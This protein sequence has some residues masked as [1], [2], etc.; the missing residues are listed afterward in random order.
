MEVTM[1]VNGRMITM[2]RRNVQS[3][4]YRLKEQERDECFE[5]DGGCDENSLPV[6]GMYYV[7]AK[8]DKR[9][10]PLGQLIYQLPFTRSSR[11]ALRVI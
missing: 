11:S 4:V 8:A 10:Y 9:A 2:R 1:F 6:Q 5:G 7:S 3:S